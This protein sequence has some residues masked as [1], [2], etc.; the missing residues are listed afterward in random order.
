MVTTVPAAGVT[1][2]MRCT[3]KVSPVEVATSWCTIVWFD[4]TVRA[5]ALSQSLPTPK[6]Q[7]LLRVVVRL[8]VGAPVAAFPVPVAPMAP[9][10]PLPVVS[11]PVKVTT[12]SEAAWLVDK[13]AVTVALVSTAGAKARHTSDVPRCVL[14]RF[15]NV[16]V[17][18][19]P[20][21]PVTVVLVPELGPSLETNASN[22]SLVAVV[23]KA[24]VTIVLAAVLLSFDAVLS[25]ASDALGVTV[26]VA[27]LF[28]LP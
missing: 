25:I 23:V 6:T 7:E 28:T 26:R 9:E 21:I 14:V 16:Q 2:A 22:S 15:T 10:P 19:P 3:Q 8:A 18:L 24:G 5:V 11:V 20:V 4:G 13:V 27:V 1:A 12:V 17:R